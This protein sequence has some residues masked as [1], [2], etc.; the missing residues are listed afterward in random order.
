MYL[1]GSWYNSCTNSSTRVCPRVP[2]CRH[3]KS[4]CVAD[5]T[6]FA[7]TPTVWSSLV[8]LCTRYE[9][10]YDVYLVR[11]SHLYLHLSLPVRPWYI[12]VFYDTSRDGCDVLRVLQVYTWCKVH[13]TL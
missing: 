9:Y 2:V 5:E 10:N 6:K 12:C 7:M 4:V 3:I 11:N 13:R 8:L 1:Q